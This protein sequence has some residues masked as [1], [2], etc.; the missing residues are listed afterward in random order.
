MDESGIP[1]Q[2]YSYLP[3]C[4]PVVLMVEDHAGRLKFHLAHQFDSSVEESMFV[5]KEPFSEIAKA[6]VMNVERLRAIAF[7]YP[8]FYKQGYH[9][10]WV[11]AKAMIGMG[12]VNQAEYNDID[13]FELE[14][15]SPIDKN[16]VLL[17]E[18]EIKRVCKEHQRNNPN[19][20][21]ENQK[22]TA[23]VF[24]YQLN[25]LNVLFNGHPVASAEAIIQSQ[26]INAYTALEIFACDL[27]EKALNTS[28]SLVLSAIDNKKPGRG[29]KANQTYIKLLA[30]RDTL[31]KQP[32]NI[33]AA[34]SAIM[35]YDIFNFESLNS[36]KDEYCGAF[37]RGKPPK[38]Q[39]C[40]E[41][42]E[43]QYFK[44][45]YVLE[46]LRNVLV[47]KAAIADDRFVER[48]QNQKYKNEFKKYGLNNIKI[49]DSLLVNGEMSKG[50]IESTIK[51]SNSL[52]KFV[53][54]RVTE[55]QKKHKGV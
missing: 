4:E 38:S 53:E 36:I 6:F 50:L 15:L 55:K 14:K 31:K 2:E 54:K 5:T 9:D 37:T 40:E 28:D 33:T 39:E 51:W 24:N 35:M 25:M 27:W 22:N 20:A 17:L 49:R 21:A 12:H 18:G 10:A 45:L 8:A 46:A 41:L 3:G 32:G 47:H 7:M 42:F 16:K 43:S 48:A 26:L 29:K 44:E 23:E 1:Q 19:A 11:R 52:L 30:V 34:G 13:K